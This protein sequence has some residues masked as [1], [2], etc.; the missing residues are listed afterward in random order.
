M[1]TEGMVLAV[2]IDTVERLLHGI[3]IDDR[4]QVVRHGGRCIKLNL[5]AE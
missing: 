3:F 2:E 4:K 1:A 5:F